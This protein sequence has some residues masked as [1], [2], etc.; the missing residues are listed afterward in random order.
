MIQKRKLEEVLVAKWAHFV[1]VRR[2]MAFV[3][4]S[5]RDA[6]LPHL[7][8]DDVTPKGTQ[9]TVSRFEL[10]QGGFLL[11]IDFSMP[12]ENNQLAVGTVECVLPPNGDVEL[13]NVIGN[14]FVQQQN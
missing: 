1:D 2:L 14:I 10:F 11:W 4:V 9:I 12:L 13:R 7:I 5:V 3:M 6:H 8:D